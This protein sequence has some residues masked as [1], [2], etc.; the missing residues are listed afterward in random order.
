MLPALVFNAAASFLLKCGLMFCSLWWSTV[1]NRSHLHLA[2]PSPNYSR[3]Q[4][5]LLST[6]S[7]LQGP[8][9]LLDPTFLC[10]NYL[11][12]RD[13]VI[14]LMHCIPESGGV[15]GRAALEESTSVAYFELRSS[16]F[17]PHIQA[18][19]LNLVNSSRFLN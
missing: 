11:V 15:T 7:L 12:P 2:C 19:L 1:H 10:R 17:H 18:F 8:F 9:I 4:L 6:S 5:T 16:A 13:S 14:S 3:L